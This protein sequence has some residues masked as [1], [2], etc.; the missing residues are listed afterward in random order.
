MCIYTYTGTY[1]VTDYWQHIHSTFI[2][3]QLRAKAS[4]R[5][6]EYRD[7]KVTVPVSRYTKARLV[8]SKVM[9]GKFQER[10]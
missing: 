7:S 9:S 8:D 5:V 2:I 10:K 6:W 1:I 4:S 3:C